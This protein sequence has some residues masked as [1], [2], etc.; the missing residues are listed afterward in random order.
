MLERCTNPAVIQRAW[1]VHRGEEGLFGSLPWKGI[2]AAKWVPKFKLFDAHSLRTIEMAK[3]FLDRTRSAGSIQTAMGQFVPVYG[4]DGTLL[5]EPK[6][7]VPGQRRRPEQEAD[8]SMLKLQLQ[9]PLD[10]DRSG[11]CTANCYGLRYAA[12]C[13]YQRP[14]RRLA[15]RPGNPGPGRGRNPPGLREARQDEY[16]AMTT[17]PTSKPLIR[18]NSIC[19]NLTTHTVTD[20]GLVP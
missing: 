12:C 6:P 14:W 16:R 10:L 1:G 3:R 5:A 4:T 9:I 19:I 17:W 18:A 20:A 13:R 7:A 2:K 8:R 11:P 15:G